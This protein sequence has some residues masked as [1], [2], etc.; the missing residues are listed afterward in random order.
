MGLMCHGTL[1]LLLYLVGPG[2]L[3]EVSL[4]EGNICPLTLCWALAAAV[5]LLRPGSAPLLV[6]IQ[7]NPWRGGYET[8]EGWVRCGSSLCSLPFFQVFPLPA[9]SLPSPCPRMPPYHSV[10]N[11]P[12]IVLRV[13]PTIVEGQHP[14]MLAIVLAIAECLNVHRS[15]IR[16]DSKMAYSQKN[17]LWGLV[18]VTLIGKQ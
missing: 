13:P 15:G 1:V 16:S 7:V 2:R 4:R 17:I 12:L 10:K 3:L 14:P 6:Q 9:F 11:L 8:W 5:G 18:L